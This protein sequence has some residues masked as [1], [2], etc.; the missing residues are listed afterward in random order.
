VFR[1]ITF[2]ALMA[3]LP[4]VIPVPLELISL[5]TA[6]FRASYGPE[7]PARVSENLVIRDYCARLAARQAMNI[8]AVPRAIADGVV[9]DLSIDNVFAE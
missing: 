9:P 1:A 3:A 8:N 2:C 7:C 4:T 6:P 5:S